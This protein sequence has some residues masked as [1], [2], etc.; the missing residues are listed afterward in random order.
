MTNKELKR[1]NRAELLEMLLEQSKEVERLKI[2]NQQLISQ[3]ES[4]QIKIDNAGSIAEAALQLNEV[5]AAA[6]KAADQYL[7]NVRQLYDVKLDKKES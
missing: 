7:E 2:Q 6:Q 4:R 1:L 3:L 5:F